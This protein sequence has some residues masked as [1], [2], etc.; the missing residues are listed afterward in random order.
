MFS[1]PASLI[2][3]AM[4]IAVNPNASDEDLAMLVVIPLVIFT[5]LMRI[6]RILN[7]RMDVDAEA[8]TA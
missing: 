5:L 8:A 2:S 1:I 7:P 4:A 6:V 3:L